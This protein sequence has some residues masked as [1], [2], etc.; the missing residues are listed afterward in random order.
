MVRV[1]HSTVTGNVH[2]IADRWN[3]TPEDTVLLASSFIFDPSV[4][5]QSLF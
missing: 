3:V 1:P 5:H 2:C 4:R